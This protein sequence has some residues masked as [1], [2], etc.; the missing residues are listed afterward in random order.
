MKNILDENSAERL[1]KMFFPYFDRAHG[2]ALV[3]DLFALR[4]I[5]V[6]IICAAIAFGFTGCLSLNP[7]KSVELSVLALSQSPAHD[8]LTVNGVF[9]A[10][11]YDRDGT[12]NLNPYPLTQAQVALILA[13]KNASIVYALAH[14]KAGMYMSWG[15]TQVQF[16]F[17]RTFPT[18]AVAS[19]T[20]PVN[21]YFMPANVTNPP[22]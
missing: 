20:V 5:A 1:W 10:F 2:I 14:D 18:T 9:G 8:S 19:N 11:T 4:K 13:D 12:Q 7:Q 21:V 17:K 6:M 3:Q 15:G 16:T 22:K